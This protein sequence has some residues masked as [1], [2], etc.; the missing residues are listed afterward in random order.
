MEH[1]AKPTTFART[2]RVLVMAGAAFLLI[3][4][5]APVARAQAEAM[6]DDENARASHEPARSPWDED[7]ALAAT[8][9]FGAPTGLLGAEIERRVTSWLAL[10]AGI[11]GTTAG[12]QG[13]AMTHLH[14]PSNPIVSL[15]AG[16]SGG[17]YQPL[18]FS[19][20]LCFSDPCEE[21]A[22][23]RWDLALWNNYE[24]SF[25]LRGKTGF[26]FRGFLGAAWLLNRDAFTCESCGDEVPDRPT[27]LPYLGFAVGRAFS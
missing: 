26:L 14:L 12:F 3:G 22:V 20:S 15:G 9:G 8:A 13:A 6:R 19:I 5:S 7:W 27:V 17:P 23:P 21:P 18:D 4:S 10:S 2:T 11:G 24:L 25:E 16:I 1:A